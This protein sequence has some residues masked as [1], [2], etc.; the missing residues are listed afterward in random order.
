MTRPKPE[1]ETTDDPAAAPAAGPPFSP[2]SHAGVYRLWPTPGRFPAD[3]GGRPE[4]LWAR[5]DGGRVVAL[6]RCRE[7]LVRLSVDLTNGV[8]L[9]A[10]REPGDVPEALAREIQERWKGVG[11]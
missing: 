9:N 4:L 10:Y 2:L 8:I 6:Y 3:C 5:P 1:P 7:C 11:R